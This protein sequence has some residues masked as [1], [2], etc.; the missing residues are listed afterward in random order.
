MKRIALLMALALP[1]APTPAVAQK[2]AAADWTG[3]VKVTEAGGYL[4]GNPDAPVRLVEYV[5]LTCGHC[6]TFHQAGM[7]A[8]VR[9][10]VATGQVSLE[11]RNFPL[12]VVDL[13]A[14][15]ASRCVGT[16]R[17]FEVTASL[18]GS[19]G[20]WINAFQTA[21]RALLETLA[22]RNDVM[23]LVSV[24]GIDGVLV[25]GGDRA[26]ITAC[27]NDMTTAMALDR[28]AK[29]ARTA[30]VN[31]TPTFSINDGL[32]AVHDW[33]SLKPLIDKALAE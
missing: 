11:M 22:S 12:N 15:T 28:M 24:G 1:L 33:A 3:T 8:L 21:D 27:A 13:I 31:G 17:Y 16:D 29:A 19:Q 10:Y 4:M 9:D 23:G 26:A 20:D 25:G 32:V 2:A 18:L 14:A 30:G 5:S 7:P 6:A